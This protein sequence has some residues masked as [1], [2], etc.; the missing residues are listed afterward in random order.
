MRSR[1][2]VSIILLAQLVFAASH[3]ASSALSRSTSR[4]KLPSEAF[5]AGL[6]PKLL[7]AQ[8]SAVLARIGGY[9]YQG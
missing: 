6:A 3:S 2:S 4:A 1:F 8:I 5:P 9:L 7:S